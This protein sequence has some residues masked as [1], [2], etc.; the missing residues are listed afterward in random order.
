[1]GTQTGDVRLRQP[2]VV[3]LGHVDS[4]KT[5]ILD[6]VR[7]TAVQAREAGGITQHIGASFIPAETL[8]V[9]CGD[10]LKRFRF[11]LR[12]PGLLF[13]DT[14][15]H[16]AFSNLRLRGGSAADIAILVV[17]STKGLEPQSYESIEILEGRRVPFMIALNKVD[18]IP[19][20]SPSP[21]G[22][23]LSSIKRQSRAVIDLLDEA[24]YRVVGELSRLGFR[25]E[26]FY[27]VKD[28]TREIAIVPVS[29]K[30]GEGIPELLAVLA[31]LTQQYMRKRLSVEE[32]PGKGIVI[33]IKEEPGLG[34]TAN[35][36]LID[37]V[38]KVG[39]TIVVGTRE[40]SLVTK[41]KAL[42][43]PK[44]LDEMRDPRDRFTPVHGVD[45]AAGVKLAAPD[46]DKAI[47][48]TPLY[49]L[50]PHEDVTKYRSLVESDIKSVIVSTDNI[51]VI[52][53]SDTLGSL[54]ALVNMLSR[55]K[56]PVRIADIGNITKR[57]VT[58]ASTVREK[59]RYL[60]VVLGFNVKP[61]PGVLEEAHSRG[62]RVL[63]DNVIYNLVDGYQEWVKEEKA[64]EAR[65]VFSKIILPAKIRILPGYVFRRSDP[66]IFGV[67]VI[68]GRLKP[69]AILMNKK[70]RDVGQVLQI[71]SSGNPLPEAE[72][73]SQVAVSVRGPTI[74]RQIREGDVLYTS[75]KSEEARILFNKYSHLLSED[76]LD[77]LREIIEIKRRD[78]PLYAY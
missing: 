12:I 29:A 40:G 66:A 46:L 42:F 50:P 77:A 61:L 20:W 35:L 55:R 39:D 71:Q 7:G 28:F 34:H 51:G 16:E 21:G 38:I 23:I 15:G 8:E 31:G 60:G 5:S 32:G 33:E 64:K 63:T 25:S 75:L 76:E 52:V 19:G 41:V 48:G 73:G 68:A 53:K 58:E 9:I 47:A 49:V 74:G 27:R 3:V 62:V 72:K 56:I 67:E 6:R 44:P 59:D 37:G 54:E 57:D 1:M 65:L 2:I 14:P 70:G 69:R 26:A 45:A 30:T 24:V 43:M 10:L 18:L 17:D 22:S 78:N 13:I 11:E 4:G 36:V